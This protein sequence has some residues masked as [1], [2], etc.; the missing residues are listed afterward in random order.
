MLDPELQ[1]G[2]SKRV[3]QKSITSEAKSNSKD[4]S[5]LPEGF[6]D[7]P[8]ADAKVTNLLLLID[9]FIY[10]ILYTKARKVEYINKDEEEWQS[11]MKEVSAAEVESKQIIAEDNEEAAIETQMEQTTD[12][13]KYYER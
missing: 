5:V 12:Q 1:N 11:F 4:S 3:I 7:D 6:F 10:N 2:D 13:I 9:I 8:V